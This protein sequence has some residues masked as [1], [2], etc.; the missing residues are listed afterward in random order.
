MNK[1]KIAFWSCFVL[2][3]ATISIG[4]YTILDQAVTITYMKE[5]YTDTKADLAILIDLINDTDLSKEAIILKL[6]DH[7]LL[8][9]IDFEQDSLGIES[10]KLLFMGDKVKKE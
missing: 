10:I 5:G 1:W 9:S 8:E 7:R 4:A 6:K 2:L 3:I